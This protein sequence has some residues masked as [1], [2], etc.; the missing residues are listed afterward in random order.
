M[1]VLRVGGVQ[2][3]RHSLARL[4]DRVQVD[5]RDD[6]ADGERD[7]LGVEP[8][9]VGGAPRRARGYTLNAP[10]TMTS[11]FRSTRWKKPPSSRTARSPVCSQP[12]SSAAAVSS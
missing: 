10:E 8:D 12:T 2:P 4:R 9:G 7:R 1:D 5:T 11:F 6:V 3:Q